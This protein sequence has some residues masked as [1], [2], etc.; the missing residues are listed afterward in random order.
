MG[1]TKEEKWWAQD[2][3]KEKEKRSKKRFQV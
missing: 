3:L 2:Q 1:L